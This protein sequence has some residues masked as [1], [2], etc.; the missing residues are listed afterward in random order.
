MLCLAL[1]AVL[2]I[3][4][5]TVIAACNGGEENGENRFCLVNADCDTDEECVGGMCMPKGP[6]G[7]E[8]TGCDEHSFCASDGECKGSAEKPCDSEADCGPG[9]F[10]SNVLELCLQECETPAD[11][12]PELTCDTAVGGCIPCAF[13]PQCEGHPDGERC[14]AEEGRCVECTDPLHCPDNYYCDLDE[15]SETLYHCVEGC[16]DDNDCS[17]EGHCVR[18]GTGPGRCVECL[19]ETA[20][21]DCTDPRR[22]RCHPSM[23]RCV[24]CFEHGQC[25]DPNLGL[26]HPEDFECVRCLDNTDCRMGHVCVPEQWECEIGCDG[27]E[28][29]PPEDGQHLIYCDTGRGPHGECVECL[30]DDHCEAEWIDAF[31]CEEGECVAGCNQDSDC[32]ERVPYC[33]V[34]ENRCVRCFEDEDCPDHLTCDPSEYFCRCIDETDP[35]NV[36]ESTK[37]CGNPPDWP[38]PHWDETCIPLTICVSEAECDGGWRTLAAPRCAGHCSGPVNHQVECPYGFCCRRVRDL[39]GNT[40]LKCVEIGQCPGDCD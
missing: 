36:C 12:S 20:T 15:G 13:D 18:E 6:S 35:R 40:N 19:P 30:G 1:F 32:P 3:A 14:L 33:L 11:C 38:N 22:P 37:Q 29:C 16:L 28:R 39:D 24:E 25:T 21:E 34:E 17:V 31:K 4:A 26:C 5:A 27:D 9:F 2:L 8:G 7:C 23:H 10:C